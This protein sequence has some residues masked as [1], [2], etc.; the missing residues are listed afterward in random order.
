MNDKSKNSNI[1]NGILAGTI[2][3]ILMIMLPFISRTIILYKLGTNYIG[4]SGLFT[5]II[6]MLSLT[7]LGFGSAISYALYKPLANKD[8]KEVN[9]LLKL[10]KN[11]YFI[12][13][14]FISVLSI[15]LIPFL[16]YLI[17]GDVPQDI[18]IYILY[19]FYIINTVSSYFFFAYKK[20]L[21][22]ANQRYDIDATV[23]TFTLIIQYI[24]QIMVLV[25]IGNYY[26]YVFILP[27]FTIINNIICSRIIDRLYPQYK[28]RGN[29]RKNQLKSIIKNAGGAFCSKIGST[30]Y[31][32]ADNIV[33][34][35]FLGLTILGKYQNYYYVISV[36]ISLFAVIHNTIRPIIG[37]RLVTRQL[38]QNWNEFK[39][40]YSIYIWLT[41]FACSFCISLYQIFEYLWAG[42]DNL[43]PDYIPYLLVVFFFVT[44]LYGLLTVY[45]EAAGIWWH[46]KFIYIISAVVNLTIN[47]ILVNIIGLSGVIISS[48]VSTLTVSIPG[49]VHII[50][51]YLFIEKS[52]K[53]EFVKMFISLNVKAVL[54]FI[55]VNQV[56]LLIKG[57]SF[58]VLLCRFIITLIIDI[59]CY[60]ILNIQS[61]EI[62]YINKIIVSK[63]T[64]RDINE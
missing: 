54:T 55:I 43:L 35:A 8:V 50:F 10:Y 4:L 3:N 38:E 27:V 63:I 24:F 19:A 60:L 34:S 12:I 21:L 7:E 61:K 53:K 64:K 25:S 40:I 39:K 20:I 18:N 26:L 28:C 29:V 59:L 58:T 52:Y 44:K 45:Q 32:S 56:T 6:Q 47:I 51:K 36:L 16:K 9:R 13:G 2:N 1:F 31:L 15:L 48:I 33:I 11:I 37:N 17:K 46:G 57:Y 14:I 49:I 22:H 23:S 41:I 30:I 42:N 62:K 5:S